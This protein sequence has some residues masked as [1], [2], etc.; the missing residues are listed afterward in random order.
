MHRIQ[1]RAPDERLGLRAQTRAL[2][3]RAP[4]RGRRG[5]KRGADGADADRFGWREG[6]FTLGHEGGMSFRVEPGAQ[7]SFTVGLKRCCISPFWGGI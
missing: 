1:L 6:V 2:G 4:H 3:P 7:V 5:P